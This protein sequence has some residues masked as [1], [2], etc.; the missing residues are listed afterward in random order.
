MRAA[1]Q[2]QLFGLN[3]IDWET[4]QDL[5]EGLDDEFTFTLDVAANQDNA[6]C[7]RFFDIHMNGLIQDWS[8][9]RCWMNPPY[10]S[11][12]A[13]WVQKAHQEAARGA[14]VVGLL[15]ARTDTR[16]WHE[17]VIA[18][19]VRF[20]KGRVRF[21]GGGPAPFPS[22]VVVWAGTKNCADCYHP[23][24]AHANLVGCYWPKGRPNPQ[25]RVILSPT[26]F[27]DGTDRCY[28]E[29]RPTSSDQQG[30]DA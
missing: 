2:K 10:G 13:K 24:G 4:P 21:S 16:W 30:E 29:K 23:W 15:P 27:K 14:L 22:A 1:A 17:H 6:K 28:C 3:R 18:Y 11:E 5:F 19:E 20:L 26:E 25:H 9:D 12:I 7:E 8:E